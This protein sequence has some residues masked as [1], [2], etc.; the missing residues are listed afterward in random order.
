MFSTYKDG[1]LG[2]GA[3]SQSLPAASVD[4][5]ASV[6]PAFMSTAQRL[7]TGLK[8]MSQ[9]IWENVEMDFKHSSTYTQLL[10]RALGVEWLAGC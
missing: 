1:T 9:L 3:N 7:S 5:L 4:C 2:E 10:R 8:S 6:G